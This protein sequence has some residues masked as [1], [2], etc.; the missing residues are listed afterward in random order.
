MIRLHV[1]ITEELALALANVAGDKDMGPLIEE[2]LWKRKE[3]RA[4]AK[5]LRLVRKER[6]PRGRRWPAKEEDEA[7]NPKPLP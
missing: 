3:I 2:W 6:P 1:Q 7:G 5:S 4:A